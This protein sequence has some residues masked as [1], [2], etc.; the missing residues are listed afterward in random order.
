M[1][2][3]EGSEREKCRRRKD[4][5][6]KRVRETFFVWF[7]FVK[8]PQPWTRALTCAFFCVIDPPWILQ[9]MPTY[10]QH[11]DFLMDDTK[12]RHTSVN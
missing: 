7:Y 5:L 8:L 9:A 3:V 2:G 10:S 4:V 6:R 1:G 11:L 12:D